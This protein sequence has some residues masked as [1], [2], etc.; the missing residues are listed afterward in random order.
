MKLYQEIKDLLPTLHGWCEP[1]KAIT[2][3]SMVLATKPS[4]IV[5]LG[6]WGG[7]SLLPMAMALRENGQGKV[8]AIDPWNAQAS[9]EGQTTTPDAEWWA[10]VAN[11]EL[12]YQHFLHTIDRLKLGQFIEVHRR[13]S[14][15][16]EIPD[17]VGILH[18]DNNHGEQAYS[19]TV[20]L[21]PK[22]MQHGYVVLDDLTWNGGYVQKAA[23]WLKENG[24]IEMHHLGT[25]AVY[26]RI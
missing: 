13:K 18:I 6:V 10:N 3:A 5:E 2:L 20:R 9:V 21:A 12:V 19:E 7:K 17:S 25:G 11:H 23:D 16:M 22:V 1:P 8:L 26:L 15:Q 14:E 24:F 4:I